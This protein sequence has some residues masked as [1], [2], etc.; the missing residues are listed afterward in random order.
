MDLW[1]C[2][3]VYMYLYVHVNVHRDMET[4]LCLYAP[5]YPSIIRPSTHAPSHPLEQKQ[6]FNHLVSN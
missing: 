4:E 1:T 6:Y 5:S 2:L 3:H